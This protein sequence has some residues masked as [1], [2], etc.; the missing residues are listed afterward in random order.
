MVLTVPTMDQLYRWLTQ[1]SINNENEINQDYLPMYN[2]FYTL[3]T[4]R[5]ARAFHT[6][7]SHL[8]PDPPFLPEVILACLYSLL[9]YSQENT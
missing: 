4:Q 9:Q 1:H 5:Q 6:S 8:D 2:L 3:F 7:S